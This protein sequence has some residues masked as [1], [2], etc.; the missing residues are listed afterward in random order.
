MDIKVISEKIVLIVKKY[1]YA[2]LVLAIGLVLITIPAR[3]NDDTTEAVK[4][5]ETVSEMTTEEQLAA[6]LS[7][8]DG[9]G[10]VEVMLTIAEGEEIVYQENANLSNDDDSSSSNT[11]TVTI[12]DSEKNQKGLVRQVIPPKYLGAVVLCQGADDPTVKLAIVDAV[13]KIT[14]LGTNCISVLKMK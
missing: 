8:I 5:T 2:I 11:D 7:K 14:G 9:A 1:R 6:L 10:T 12:T 4:E 3:N 13:S